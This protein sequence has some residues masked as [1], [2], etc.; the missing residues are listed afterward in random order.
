MNTTLVRNLIMGYTSAM[1]G[2]NVK[3]MSRQEL[4]HEL[5]LLRL[6]NESYEEVIKLTCKK[7]DVH[8]AEAWGAYFR[9]NM[10]YYLHPQP[11]KPTFN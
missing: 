11:N 2:S 8:E 4:E 6:F 10:D 9:F 3:K 7:V 5:T 1:N